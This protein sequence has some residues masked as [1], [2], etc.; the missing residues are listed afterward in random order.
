MQGEGPYNP[1]ME[2]RGPTWREEAVVTDVVRVKTK[3]G[4]HWM[5]HIV[6]LIV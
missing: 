3:M 5:N 2:E 1:C 4:S 6:Y